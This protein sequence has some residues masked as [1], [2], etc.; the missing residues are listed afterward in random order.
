MIETLF[1]WPGFSWFALLLA[2]LT[3]AALLRLALRRLPPAAKTGLAGSFAKNNASPALRGHDVF[4][5]QQSE[6]RAQCERG[7]LA[8]SDYDAMQYEAQQQLELDSTLQNAGSPKAVQARAA[9][10]W[11]RAVLFAL[12]CLAPLV[13][14]L[15]YFPAGG[16]LGAVD[17]Y[18]VAGQL[19]QL[20]QAADPAARQDVLQ[21]L[22]AQLDRQTRARYADPELLQ[23]H[24]EVLMGAG[25]YERAIA[26]YQ[27]LLQRRGEDAG[28]MALLAEAHYLKSIATQAGQHSATFPDAASQWL[29]RA[30]Q[31][32]PAQPRALG[33]AGVRGFA[34]G[35]YQKAMQAWQRALAA[36]APGSREYNM[37]HSGIVAAQAKL[38]DA[39]DAGQA[40]PEAFVKLEVKIDRQ[41]L[42]SSDAPGTPVFVFARAAN[43]PRIPLAARRL[44]L[45]DLPASITLSER[46]RM[47]AQSLADSDR[48]IVAARLARSNQP[49]GASGDLLSAEV[50][51]AVQRA[52]GQRA[53]IEQGEVHVLDINQL[54][55]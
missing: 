30:L 16:S 9:V 12:A 44:Q 53:A 46:D 40:L 22:L 33:L 54:Q 23:L 42:R 5:Q 17:Q 18:V 6:W 41:Q 35:D 8:K 37:I 24:A 2:A 36:Y 43:G 45:A 34:R 7:E 31:L 50:T 49:A 32:Q 47:T 51:V 21:G 25:N 11:Q 39:A 26:T 52:A 48:V 20:R 55:R 19:Q 27:R 14:G 1:A 38:G 4:A 15:L 3:S 28:V 13:A 29:D 10:G